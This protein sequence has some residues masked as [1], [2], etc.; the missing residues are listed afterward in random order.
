M[1]TE[2]V[3]PCEGCG[4]DVHFL[5]NLEEGPA[6]VW[7]DGLLSVWCTTCWFARVVA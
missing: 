4:T 1:T 3:L 2:V 6:K 7:A 5:S